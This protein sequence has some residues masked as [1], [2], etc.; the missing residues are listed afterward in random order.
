MTSVG[1]S[2]IKIE[3]ISVIAIIALFLLFSPSIVESKLPP[4]T[5]WPIMSSSLGG[6]GTLTVTN[7]NNQ[8]AIVVLTDK[9]RS[10]YRA[11]YIRGGDVY[12]IKNIASNTYNLYFEYGEDWDRE[13]KTFSDAEDMYKIIEPFNFEETELPDEIRYTV[14]QLSLPANPKNAGGIESVNRSEFPLLS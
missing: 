1:G 12:T 9:M 8:D 5:G 7:S 3:T 4:L 11:V 10:V 2:R 13:S 6:Y 14:W